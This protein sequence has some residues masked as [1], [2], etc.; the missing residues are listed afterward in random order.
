MTGFDADA[1]VAVAGAG[2]DAAGLGGVGSEAGAFAAVVEA[3]FDSAVV[4]GVAVAGS[5]VVG[6]DAGAW[7]PRASRT[8]ASRPSWPRGFLAGRLLGRGAGLRLRS[9][10]RGGGGRLGRRPRLRLRRRPASTSPRL[11]SPT[12]ARPSRPPS[13]SVCARSCR[14]H[15][16]ACARRARGGSARLGPAG[17]RRGRRGHSGG[18]GFVAV[19]AA[20]AAGRFGHDLASDSDDASDEVL[21]FD[22]HGAHCRSTAPHRN[23]IAAAR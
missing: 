16:C 13:A 19:I 8:S 1:F 14:Q 17:P 3:G 11:R 12:S 4:R 2:F 5:G 9:G 20:E 22:G 10:R 7:R 18:V 15:A 23:A 21:G 6:F